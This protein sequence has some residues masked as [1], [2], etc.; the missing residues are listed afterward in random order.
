MQYPCLLAA[1][2]PL[3]LAPAPEVLSPG[4]PADPIPVFI[5]AGQSNMEGKA[6]VSLLEYQ[7]DQE[8]TRGRFEHF[9]SGDDWNE[10]SDVWIKFLGRH[11]NLTVGYGSPNCIGPE[12]D[13]GHVMGDHFDQPVLIIKTAWGGKS[14]YRDFR[15]PSAG[16]PDAEVLEA[17]L[18]QQRQRNPDTTMEQVEGSFGHFYRAMLEDVSGTLEGVGDL[19]PG[20][21]G[22]DLELAG[23]VWFQGWNDMINDD[24][25]AEYADN[26]AHFI[27]DVRRDLE[28][29]ELPFVIGQLGVGG[30]ENV[31]AKKQRFKDA[32]AA[33]A[34]LREFRGNVAVVR[35]DQFWDHVAQAVFDEGW[36][37][38]VEEW[39]KVGS[40]YPYHYLGST[41]TY[42]D[43]GR[44]FAEALLELR[45]ESD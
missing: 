7:L 42:S 12:L 27:R 24:Y 5:L 13:F 39:E 11:G 41:I 37:D 16:L 4:A 9:V 31:D 33:P 30:E 44:A 2:A 14:L 20:Y 28:A 19:F 3:A 8:E 32:Q 23:F 25:T 29:P 26:M 36:R 45:G 35:T 1:L 17:M 15:P 10:R 34:E 43:I 22:Q 18:E 21:A 40:D 6:K 38:H